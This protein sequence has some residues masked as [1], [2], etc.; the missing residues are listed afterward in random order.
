M[1][2]A[3]MTEHFTGRTSESSTGS[4]GRLVTPDGTD[5]PLRHASVHAEARGG[6]ARV[7][8]TQRFLNPHD[9]PL[10]VKYLLPLPSDGAVSGF[11]FHI[12][13]RR[14]VGEIDRRVAARRRF[15]QAI[16]SG[17]TAA[18]LEQDRSSLFT[19]EVGNIPPRTEIVAEIIVDQRLRWLDEGCWEWRFPTVVGPR[20]MGQ[21]G[22]VADAQKV[23][24]DVS[25]H[26][27]PAQMSLALVVGDVLSTA[28][29]VESPS[30]HLDLRPDDEEGLEVV[31]RG[32]G[33]VPLDRDVVVRWQVAK[34]EM[35]L[36]LSVARPA[37][38]GHGGSAYGLLTIVPPD[39]KSNPKPLARDLIFLIDTS[40]SM[41]GRPLEQAARVAAAMIDTL[42]PKDQIELIA[43]GWEPRR[44]R[45]EPVLATH[46]G[47]RAAMKWLRK[48]KASGG[49]EMR[50]GIIEALRPLRSN[51]QRQVVLITD[52]L[53]GFEQEIIATV[54]DGLPPNCRL[55]TIGVGSAPNRSLTGPA[56]RAGRGVELVVGLEEDA[57]RV[58]TRL[59]ARTTAPLLTDV[60]VEGSC[61]RSIAPFRIPDLFAGAPLLVGLELAPEGGPIQVRALAA[62][63]EAEEKETYRDGA[64]GAFVQQIDAP[65]VQ[66]GQG[67][68][69]MA[70]L[71][72]RERVEDLETLIAAGG[73]GREIDAQI[74]GV[75]LTFQISTRLTSWLAITEDVTVDPEQELKATRQPH[76]LPYGTSIEGF[77]LRQSAPVAP[78]SQTMFEMA[79]PSVATRTLAGPLGM[80]G[81]P[82]IPRRPA[83]PQPPPAPAQPAPP[84]P[85][86]AG[87]PPTGGFSSPAGPADPLSPPAPRP[88]APPAGLPPGSALPAQG[89]AG[90]ISRSVRTDVK[91][92]DTPMKAKRRM[93]EDSEIDDS[94]FDDRPTGRY[95]LLEAEPE[96]EYETSADSEMLTSSGMGGYAPEEPEPS[97][98]APQM[99]SGPMIAESRKASPFMM[100]LIV[101]AIVIAIAM[102]LWLGVRGCVGSEPTGAEGTGQVQGSGSS[103]GSGSGEGVHQ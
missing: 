90:P 33:G 9:Q 70:A 10:L 16:A 80:A 69:G 45:K 83:A 50:R 31:F 73:N 14:I 59:L 95:N 56:A 74:E 29:A 88:A 2:A 7:V 6:I 99:S 53:I 22:R 78:M 38:V 93:V 68:Q 44:W 41:H 24:V 17:R 97:V 40:G 51:A 30:H 47:K 48:L 12:G 3:L 67:D 62:S 57:E 91:A 81:P 4:G 37:D 15:E 89:Q 75:G 77:G 21:S 34:T 55:H 18:L 76:E 20:Y 58:A 87:Q 52:G 71:F 46:N 102:A 8:L 13:D 26:G 28:D 36:S 64:S 79:Q 86:M 23:T 100:A 54:L 1:S 32:D 92:A 85:L 82:P 72:G 19:Q 103:S 27:L 66:L 5:L 101:L 35:G 60:T 63:G 39:P 25:E 65:Q 98:Y 11:C 96:E 94:A 42:G 49:T 84:R 61:L 43:F